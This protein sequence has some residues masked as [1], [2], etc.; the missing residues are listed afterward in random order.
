MLTFLTSLPKEIVPVTNFLISPKPIIP[1]F[2]CSSIPVA[3][4][5]GAMF[6][7]GGF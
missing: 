7:H 4:R 1:S 6:K 5:S 2:H 3:E